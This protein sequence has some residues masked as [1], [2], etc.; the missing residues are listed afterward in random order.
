[1]SLFIPTFICDRILCAQALRQDF[2]DVESKHSEKKAAFDRVTV[3]LAVEQSSIEKECDMAQ[4][5]DQTVS[6][7]VE[8]VCTWLCV[9]F[10]DFRGQLR[11]F[12]SF[13]VEL[14][15]SLSFH[16]TRVQTP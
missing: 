5:S 13:G 12:F 8:S 2:M 7:C 1:M 16:V 4:V 14:A 10:S 6:M 15:S 9:Y 3:G 11:D